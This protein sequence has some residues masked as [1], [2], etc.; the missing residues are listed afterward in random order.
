MLLLFGAGLLGLQCAAAGIVQA[1]EREASRTANGSPAESSYPDPLHAPVP[2]AWFLPPSPEPTRDTESASEDDPAHQRPLA[3][4]T[5]QAEYLRAQLGRAGF[6]LGDRTHLRIYKESRELEVH[7]LRDG[8][9]DH[10]RTFRI[11]AISGSLGPKLREGDL[12]APEGVYR[13]TRDRMHPTSDFHLAFNLGFPNP[14]DRALGATG[15]NIMIH[16]GCASNGCFAMTDYYMEQLWVLV[17]AALD[18]GQYAVEVHVFPFRMSEENL[19]R[20]A[21]SPH[22][23]FWSTLVPLERYFRRTGHPPLIDLDGPEYRV[24]GAA[25][26]D[27]AAPASTAAP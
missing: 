23:A 17:E 4:W 12:Q 19:S 5:E 16:G 8:S 6:R 21:E 9:F 13:I 7:L 20:H 27:E 2:E 22:R 3:A 24:L 18:A 26:R 10:F 14:R 1:A 25:P 15:S 11:C